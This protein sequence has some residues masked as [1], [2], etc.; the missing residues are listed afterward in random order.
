M[1]ALPYSPQLHGALCSQCPLYGEG[2]VVPPKG[3]YDAPIAFVSDSPTY[4]DLRA[5]EPLSGAA[6]IKFDEMLWKLG[7]RRTDVWK[8][9]AILCRFQVPGLEGKK[10]YQLTSYMAWLRKMN[11]ERRRVDQPARP[12]P[13]EC[14]KPRLDGELRVLEEA[15]KLRGAPNGVVV[16]PL[17]PYA[18]KY[19]A[20]SAQ[21]KPASIQKYRGSVLVMPEG[22]SK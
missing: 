22:H 11:A 14:C 19:V 21:G 1:T 13:F 15:A 20:G 6:G 10:R 8:T 9:N 3:P 7:L 5:R 18:L 17:G 16:M 4:H 12:S 2:T